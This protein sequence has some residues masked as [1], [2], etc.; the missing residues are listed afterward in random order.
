[1][2]KRIFILC[3]LV[4]MLFGCT[5]ISNDNISIIINKIIENENNKYNEYRIGY[6]YYLP[7]GIN[8]DKNND[9]NVIFYKNNVKYYMYVDVVSYYYNVKKEYKVKDDAYLSMSINKDDKYGYLEINESNNKYLI[10]I[11]Y[12]YAKIEVIVEENDIC[13]AITDSMLILSSIKFNDDI[14]KSMLEEDVLNYS[15]E[16]FNI[17]DTDTN[18][19]NFLKVIEE[20]D[21]YSEEEVPDYDLIN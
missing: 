9:F 4:F 6:K 3:L 2:M 12:N 1:M 10:E 16:S 8:I 15:E 5:K 7:S 18:E 11:M 20:F 21:N 13:H 14:I 19:S 17:F